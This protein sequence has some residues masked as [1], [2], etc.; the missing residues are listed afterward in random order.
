MMQQ[1][2]G[3]PKEE[4]V[5]I[6]MDITVDLPAELA[7]EVERLG[8]CQFDDCRYDGE[9]RRMTASVSTTLYRTKKGA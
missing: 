8:I 9:N 5:R 4:A 1:Y 6:R 7:S 2:Q 3:R